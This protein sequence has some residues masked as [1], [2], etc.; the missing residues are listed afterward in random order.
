MANRTIS[1]TDQLYDYLLS[2]SLREPAILRRLRKETAPLPHSVMQ[3]APEQGQFMALLLQLIGAVNTIELG[4]YTGYSSLWTAL[5]LPPQGT[6][7]ACDVNE[8]WTSMARRYWQEAGVAQKVDLRLAPAVETLDALLKEGK[9]GSFD[10]IFIDADKE[11]YDAYY[12]R[13][14]E[15]LRAGGLIAVDNV[16]WSGRVADPLATDGPTAAIRAFNL[17]LR[18]D[19]RIRLSV[20]PI[21]DGLTLALKPT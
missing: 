15:L 6:I 17:K 7:I 2:S 19:D 9:R 18:D 4:V 21:A 13:S 12:E 11:S 14:L 10:F 5:A 20:V 1:M 8:E 16:L 3:T